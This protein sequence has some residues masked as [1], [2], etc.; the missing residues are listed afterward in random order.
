MIPIGLGEYQAPQGLALLADR[1]G[2]LETDQWQDYGVKQAD[3]AHY[4]ACYGQ[5][6]ARL[7]KSI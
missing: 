4:L 3:A 6:L 7:G 1:P 5:K 2:E